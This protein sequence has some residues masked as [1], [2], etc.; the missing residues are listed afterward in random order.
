MNEFE[1]NDFVEVDSDA[2]DRSGVDLYAEFLCK[3]EKPKDEF[4]YCYSRYIGVSKELTGAA[5]NLYLWLAL[6]SDVNT[7]RVFV[8]SLSQRRALEELDMTV[9]TYY[10]ALNQ[11][12]YFGLIKGDNAVY[13]INP[14]Y[15]WKG[16]ADMRAKFLRVYPKL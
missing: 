5:K 8:Q 14:S 2:D 1:V 15:M 3:A 6:N 10:R 13:Y 7:G 11:L 9:G 12:K 4:V 16:T